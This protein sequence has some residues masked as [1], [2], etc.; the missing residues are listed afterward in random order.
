MFAVQNILIWHWAEGKEIHNKKRLFV[1]VVVG[2]QF[3]KHEVMKLDQSFSVA[4]E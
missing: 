1:V 3:L 4:Y 2:V